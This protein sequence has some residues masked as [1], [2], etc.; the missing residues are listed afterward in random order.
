MSETGTIQF[1]DRVRA[2]GEKPGDG[3]H[4]VIFNRHS[5]F[6]KIDSSKT[7]DISILEQAK[8]DR[9]PILIECSP[10][11]LEIISVKELD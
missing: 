10:S 9:K 2:V 11:S 8:D 4:T 3:F 6:Y 7:G 1:E 5:A